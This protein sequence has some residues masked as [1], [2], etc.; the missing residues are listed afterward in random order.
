MKQI[1][2]MIAVMAL[3]GCDSP[4]ENTVYLELSGSTTTLGVEVLAGKNAPEEVTI[5]KHLLK[6][7]NGTFKAQPN[8]INGQVYFKNENERYLY[9]YDQAEGGEKSW[10]LNLRKPDGKKDYFSGGW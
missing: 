7:F 6:S 8:L 5:S 1:L 2:L 3:A 9:F 10:S 4:D